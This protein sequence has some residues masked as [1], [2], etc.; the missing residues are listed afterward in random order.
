MIT[1]LDFWS[2]KGS[3]Y[4][5]ND[6]RMDLFSCTT[7]LLLHVELITHFFS[8]KR[9]FLKVVDPSCPLID[10]PAP[11]YLYK[12]KPRVNLNKF[13]ITCLNK[14]Q[15]KTLKVIK[16]NRRVTTRSSVGNLCL[17]DCLLAI[18]LSSWCISFCIL[19]EFDVYHF[20]FNVLDKELKNCIFIFIQTL[21]E[22]F[23][24]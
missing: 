21:I 18:C 20:P 13:G 19:K 7:F 9:Y 10:G 24:P 17:S 23:N 4:L 14:F 16:R 1:V 15:W 11:F 22:S 3:K 12:M 2:L 6:F 8:V 5:T